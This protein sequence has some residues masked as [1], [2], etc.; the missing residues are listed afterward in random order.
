VRVSACG[1]A[2]CLSG[3]FC[4]PWQLLSA[5]LAGGWLLAC[6]AGGGWL[7]AWLAAVGWLLVATT[8]LLGGVG[9]AWLVA[10]PSS[11]PLPW[12]HHGGGARGLQVLVVVPWWCLRMF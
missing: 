8:G 4:W 11:V 1:R 5:G 3:C 9:A 6:L 2:G 12:C 10:P 7:L